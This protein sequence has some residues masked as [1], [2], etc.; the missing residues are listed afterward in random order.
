MFVTSDPAALA[1]RPRAAALGTFDGVHAGHRLVVG[2]ARV[3][4][5]VPTVVTFDPHPRRVL[6][7]DVQVISSL[8][9]R[10]ELLSA[11]GV[12]D[13][14][15]VEFTA[16]I[17]RLPPQEWA[18]RVLRPIG[19]RRVA[20]GQNFRFGHRAAGDADTLRRMGFQVDVTPLSAGA[21]SSR[22]RDLVRAGELGAAGELLGRP[23]EVEGTVI[24]RGRRRLSLAAHPGLVLPPTGTYLGRALGRRAR[25]TID[26]DRAR[27]DL[28]FS[29]PARN[30]HAASARVELTSTSTSPVDAV[31]QRTTPSPADHL[32]PTV[33]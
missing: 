23:C 14:L 31:Q 25:V 5:L 26:A 22:I 11:A 3:D 9:R 17:S 6:G 19:A 12:H 30:V 29:L 21:S 15:V 8:H 20:I 28:R 10:L 1:H 7:R 24:T 27:I 13:V 33:A 16:A 2:R 4:G 18:D 32:A